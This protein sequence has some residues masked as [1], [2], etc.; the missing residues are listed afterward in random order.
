VRLLVALA[1]IPVVVGGSNSRLDLTVPRAAHTATLLASGEVLVAGGCS[2]DSCE[3][4]ERGATTEL[5]EPQ[6]KR[7]R[8]GPQM[9][10]QRVSHV[11]A[12]LADG[13]VLIAG[14]WTSEG[15]TASA[16]LFDPAN[17]RFTPTGALRTARGGATATVLRDGRVLVTGGS[18]GQ[19]VTRSAELYDPATGR[20]SATGS[21]SS[22]RGG[23]VAVRLKDGRVLV[24]GGSN[25]SAVL[26]GTEVYEPRTGRFR[27]GPKLRVAR[28]KHAA[29]TLRDGTVLV[30]GGSSMADYRGRYSSAEVV[31]VRRGRSRLVGSMSQRRFKLPDAVTLLADGSV[32]VVGGSRWVERYDARTRRF[33]RVGAIDDSLAFAT[34]TRISR[35]QVLVAGGYRDDLSVTRASWLVQV[36]P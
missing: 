9:S 19:R 20:F 7:F 3:L 34:A 4:D 24:V 10:S 36:H 30:V 11:A 14:G 22:A 23:H 29:V 26:A 6:A 33:R 32:L 25:G 15:L 2:V 31:D 17:P 16:E 21:M 35:D 27:P 5:Y 13:R 12:R 8:S 1:L 18:V 28:H